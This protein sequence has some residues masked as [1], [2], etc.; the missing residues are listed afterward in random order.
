MPSWDEIAE[1]DPTE[2]GLAGPAFQEKASPEH[3]R[4]LTNRF[5]IHYQHAVPFDRR[6][7]DDAWSRCQ[8][9]SC[10]AERR[11][12]MAEFGLL[13]G[14]PARARPATR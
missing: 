6:V 2:I 12:A 9:E 13:P 1:G 7:L 14:R 11:Q 8:G 10:E 3:A 5:A 4:A